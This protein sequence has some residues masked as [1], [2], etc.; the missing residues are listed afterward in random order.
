MAKKGRGVW[1]S[2]VVFFAGMGVAFAQGGVQTITLVDPLG[3]SETF[4]TVATN[5]ANFLFVDIAIPLSV[6]MVLVG[7]FQMMTSAGE[8]EKISQAKKTI[9][10]AAIGLAIAIVAGGIT[11]LLKNILTGSS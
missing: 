1:V 2:T 8:P 11:T 10:Y 6:I 7:A 3:G 4:A 5:I 9:L